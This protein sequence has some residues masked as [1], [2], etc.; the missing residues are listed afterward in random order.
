MTPLSVQA[1]SSQAIKC[2]QCFF[3]KGCVSPH[4]NFS[5]TSVWPEAPVSIGSFRTGHAVAERIAVATLRPENVSFF[6]DEEKNAVPLLDI[7][8][9]CS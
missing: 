4:R 1:P 2:S 3:H 6:R 9:T 7:D 8:T 5:S